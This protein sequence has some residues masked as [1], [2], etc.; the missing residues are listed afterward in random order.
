MAAAQ[1][2]GEE[3]KVRPV[4]DNFSF[5]SAIDSRLGGATSLCR[6]RLRSKGPCCAVIDLHRA[7]LQVRVAQELW[8]YET[9][10]MHG[11]T[12]LLTCLGFGLS[13]TPKLMAIIVDYVLRQDETIDRA[14]CEYIDDIHIQ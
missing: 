13:V 8:C 6:N 14:A 12:F 11:K 2:K 3:E 4:L 10:R 9:V 7:Y 5:N 1:R